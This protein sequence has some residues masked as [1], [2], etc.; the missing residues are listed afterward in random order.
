MADLEIK[1]S[2]V[3][4][5]AHMTFETSEHLTHIWT[6]DKPY[7]VGVYPKG[8]YGWFVNV[9]A[10]KDLVAMTEVPEDLRTVLA[11]AEKH[12]CQWVEFD[13]DG[14]AIADLPSWEW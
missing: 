14:N 12:D 4:S 11:F 9:P 13:R 1:R 2:L 6:F 10:S 5:T 3:L 8:E 7:P